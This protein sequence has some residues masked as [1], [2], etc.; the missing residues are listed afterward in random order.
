MKVLTK[1]LCVGM[2]VVLVAGCA[3]DGP[4]VPTLPTH[5]QSLYM[6]YQSQPKNK[7]FVVAIDPNGDFAVGYDYDKP[8]TKEAY[9]VALAQCKENC[10]TYGVLSDP[11]I[12]AVNDK[13][14]HEDAIS[15]AL[16]AE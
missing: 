13:I 5:A 2:F 9:Q 12:Y 10:K 6:D 14:V 1:L 11:H 8:T 3:S 15:K 7:V 16:A 4:Y